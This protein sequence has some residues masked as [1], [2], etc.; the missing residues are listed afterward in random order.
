MLYYCRTHILFASINLEGV[1]ATIS[2]EGVS[3]LPLKTKEIMSSRRACTNYQRWRFLPLLGNHH[4]TTMA[5]PGSLFRAFWLYVLVLYF[6]AQST[7]QWSY[8]DEFRW[9]EQA[10]QKELNLRH[11]GKMTFLKKKA[12]PP[13]R[14]ILFVHLGKAGGD[15]IRTTLHT[16]CS[17]SPYPHIRR[18]CEQKF[19]EQGNRETLLSQQTIGVFH[20]KYL[21]PSNAPE[22]ATTFLWSLRNP[23]DRIKSWF[24]Y[25]H[26]DNCGL[27]DSLSPACRL[28]KATNGWA[29]DFYRLCFANVEDFAL[30]LKS[31]SDKDEYVPVVNTNTSTTTGR[32]CQEIARSGV[33]GQVWGGEQQRYMEFYANRDT[34]PYPD[35]GHLFFNH[36]YYAS[37]IHA[38]SDKEVMVVR[39]EHL[40]EDLQGIESILGGGTINKEDYKDQTHGSEQALKGSLSKYGARALCCSLQDEIRIFIEVLELASN[41]DDSKKKQTMDNLY[42]RCTVSSFTDLDHACGW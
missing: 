4:T 41:L 13:S 39:T 7:L 29:F 31:E 34:L 24:Y 22:T 32:T 16:S 37:T 12:N 21:T 28:Q 42:E 18:R 10:V 33:A 1:H 25:S 27:V 20:T 8:S 26:P 2:V 30:A 15:T 38:Y 36:M 14:K 5:V 9:E 11:A 35:E 3:R 23:I 40:W 17:W 19:R 6:G